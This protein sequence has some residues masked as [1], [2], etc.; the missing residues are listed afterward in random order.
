MYFKTN[1]DIKLYWLFIYF[2][3]NKYERCI[4]YDYV[5]I[6]VKNVKYFDIIQEFYSKLN[7]YLTITI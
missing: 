1:I 2:L 5:S 7:Y 6:I 4:I 3:T